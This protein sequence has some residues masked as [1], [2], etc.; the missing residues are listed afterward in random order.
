LI[1]HTLPVMTKQSLSLIQGPIYLEKKLHNKILLNYLIE[2]P[3]YL[4][5]ILNN[6]NI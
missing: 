2:G 5:N 3:I 6:K 4:E 1:Q